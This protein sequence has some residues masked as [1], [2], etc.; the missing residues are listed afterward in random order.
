M[1]A[2][3]LASGFVVTLRI[4]PGARAQD[5]YTLTVT[6]VGGGSV[7]ES[8][9]ENWWSTNFA[10]RMKLTFNNSAISENLA[11]F[12]MPIVFSSSQS[13]FWNHVQTNGNDTRFVD[14]DN[15]TELYYEFEQ[16]SHTTDSMVAWVKVPQVDSAS[17]TDFIWVYYGNSTTN[18]NSYLNGEQVWSN[19]YAMVQHLKETS[20]VHYDSTSNNWD[21]T[22]ISVTQQGSQIGKTDGADEFNGASNYVR[23]G[24]LDQVSNFTVEF[25]MKPDSVTGWRSTVT[26]TE[27][28]GFQFDPT[29]VLWA[30]VNDGV[31]TATIG[32]S[33]SGISIGQWY[34]V[35][36]V[37]DETNND[38]YLYVNG[39]LKNSNTAMAN[40]VTNNNN[41]LFGSWDEAI[42]YFDGILDEVYISDVSRSAAWIKAF[43]QY[44]CDQSK[45]AYASEESISSTYIYGTVVTLTAFADVGWSF[46]GWS[47]DAYGTDN[48]TTVTMTDN[49][50][51]IAT[52]IRPTLQMSPMNR[53]CRK[54]GETFPIA[55]SISDESGVTGFSFEIDYNTSLLDYV[56]VTWNTWDEG[57][58]VV[59]EVDGKITGSMSGS[60]ISCAR[61]LLTVQFSAAYYHMWK[62]ES[63][64]SGWKNIQTGT[65]YVQWANLSYPTIPD[66]RYERGGLNQINVGPDFAYTFSPI[67]GDIDNDGSVNVND[68]ST[69]AAYFDQTNPE[70]SLKG[71]SIIDI[72]DLVVIA[73]NFNYTYIP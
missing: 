72:F 45:F 5:H 35:V 13:S 18:F 63:T 15:A 51:V 39:T 12:P 43:Y 49:K 25:W 54:Y 32:T 21:S 73:A 62:D 37:W 30:G 64:V 9:G 2:M 1:I 42:E 26:K 67:Q 4:M 40:H 24:D 57:T 31:W 10:Y 7:S 38:L 53:I 16:F 52:F 28:Y 8:T 27:D 3:I 36:M 41:L 59:D 58:I 70:Y 47:G 68:L 33:V 50:T 60:A 65:I 71:D 48:P 20:G 23:I 61:T 6:V 14:A 11:N 44:S 19:N 22:A 34:H 29:G 55:I 46:G 56:G 66:L 69:V 17:A